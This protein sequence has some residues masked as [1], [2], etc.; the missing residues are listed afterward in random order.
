M[1]KTTSNKITILDSVHK[2]N[3][4]CNIHGTWNYFYNKDSIAFCEQLSDDKCK[5]M[6][7]KDG[8]LTKIA[9]DTEAR[10]LYANANLDQLVFTKKGNNESDNFQELH[11][12]NHGKT[13]LLYPKIKRN[14]A[15]CII[16]NNEVKINYLADNTKEYNLGQPAD[17]FVSDISGA[18]NYLIEK[19]VYDYSAFLEKDN[20]LKYIIC[21]W[22]QTQAEYTDS[23]FD[24]NKYKLIILN[25]ES[26]TEY[27]M[28]SSPHEYF[29]SRQGSLVLFVS[30]ESNELDDYRPIY[31]LFLINTETNEKIFIEKTNDSQNFGSDK[32]SKYFT[33]EFIDL[34]KVIKYQI[35][36]APEL[37]K[38]YPQYF[39]HGKKET[40]YPYNI[41]FSRTNSAKYYI[42]ME[43]IQKADRLITFDSPYPLDDSQNYLASYKEENKYEYLLME[44]LLDAE[45]NFYMSD[46]IKFKVYE[47]DISEIIGGCS[48]NFHLITDLKKYYDARQLIKELKKHYQTDSDLKLAQIL[49][50]E[51]VDKFCLF[52]RQDTEKKKGKY[53][54]VYKEIEHRL[55]KQNKLPT[56]WKS[57]QDL[58]RV[59]SGIYDD[60]I[61]HYIED[62]ISPQHIDV[63]VPQLNCAFEYQGEQHFTGI[64]F[65]GGDK[66]LEK[67]I[68]LDKKKRKL[69]IKNK[70]LLVEWRYDEPITRDVLNKKLKN[71][72]VE[73]K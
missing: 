57:E 58:F 56:Q 71:I 30:C 70:V 60:A 16:V 64:D 21:K 43:L 54:D 8:K 3:Y 50:S 31:S 39:G 38:E 73:L 47:M 40:E 34:D 63:F 55:I 49:K 52:S 37:I 26:R 41:F 67:R 69:C 17:L 65:F 4:E 33:G 46:H 25:Q 32:L 61:F 24:K 22:A 36:I 35:N 12:Y 15:K 18:S 2:F 51:I 14:R 68:N 1:F 10:V 62:W 7:Y 13:C 23:Y 66:V 29:T 28:C 48:G 9:D 5:I 72:G 20:K 19:D 6:L 42:A 44:N 27:H 53:A 11:I 45:K 59:I